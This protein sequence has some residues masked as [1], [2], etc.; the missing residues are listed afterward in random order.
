MGGGPADAPSGRSVLSSLLGGAFFGWRWGVIL[1]QAYV[2][3]LS[4]GAW[5]PMVLLTFIFIII[6]S[7]CFGLGFGTFYLPV[8][9]VCFPTAIQLGSCLPDQL[10]LR[11][12]PAR[13]VSSPG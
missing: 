7:F 13:P 6:I 9:L 10:F 8:F 2:P 11:R 4:F 3:C 1:A 12:L 5:V